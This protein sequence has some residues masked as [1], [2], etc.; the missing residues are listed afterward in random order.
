MWPAIEL[1]KSPLVQPLVDVEPDGS[2]RHDDAAAGRTSESAEPLLE[3]GLHSSTSMK[4]CAVGDVSLHVGVPT[5][6]L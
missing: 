3:P 4:S 5:N 1:P 6:A 2:W